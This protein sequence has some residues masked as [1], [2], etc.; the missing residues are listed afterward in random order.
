[1]LHLYKSQ[2]LRYCR[3]L[4]PQSTW[5]VIEINLCVD[6]QEQSKNFFCPI[7]ACVYGDPHIVTLDGLKYTFNGKGEY[8]LI[9]TEADRFS[10]QGR[11]VEAE[12]S[13]GGN[14]AASVFSAL[15]A[16]QIYSD[17]VQFEL[18]RRGIDVRVNG[19]ILDFSDLDELPFNN[20]TVSDRG[21]SIY[22]AL[23]NSGAYVEVRL[24]NDIISTVL[25]SL[26]DSFEGITRGL[27]GSYNG[28][29]HDDL[30]PNGS[31]QP[32]SI[33]SSLEE[34]HKQ[35]GVTCK[36]KYFCVSLYDKVPLIQG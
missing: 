6:Q 27:M 1:M 5:L 31:I 18:S 32:I 14:A 29:I 15:V 35:F 2:A 12:M 11:M 36:L 26:P 33:N 23:F 13:G 19:E 4:Q 34:I 10:L 28:D 17:T 25:V 24:E 7:T 8:I 20:V 9:A 22:S 16:K 21:N 30:L 3:H